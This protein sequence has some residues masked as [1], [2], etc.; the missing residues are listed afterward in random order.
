MVD[1]GAIRLFFYIFWAPWVQYILKITPG[2]DKRV[3]ETYLL[4]YTWKVFNNDGIAGGENILGGRG[5][6][7]Y[8][9]ID[10]LLDNSQVFFKGTVSPD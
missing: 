5:L 7:L 4:G 9:N 6:I 10:P 1:K 3:I 8:Q 2:R